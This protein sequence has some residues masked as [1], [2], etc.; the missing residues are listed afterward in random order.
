MMRKRMMAL[1]NGRPWR[2]HASRVRII[3]TPGPIIGEIFDDDGESAD[4][5]SAQDSDADWVFLRLEE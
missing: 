5:E 4:G 1:V 3:E 2:V